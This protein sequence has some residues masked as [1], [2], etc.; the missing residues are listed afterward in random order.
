M[1]S[2]PD[3]RG[4]RRPR[5]PAASPTL[6]DVARLAGVH[7]ATVSR[8]L[9]PEK[10][11]LVSPA[12]RAKVETAARELGYR[13]D[14][15]ARSLR[16]GQTTTVGVVVADLGNLF[17]GSVLRGLA[18][19]LERRGFMAL[20]AETQDDH[21]RLR[22]SLENLLSR[23]VDAVIVTSAR[24]GDE[25]ALQAV[26]QSGTPIVLAVRGIV[27]SDLPTV[28]SDDVAGGALA[29]EYLTKLGHSRIAELSGP[30]DVK[31][32]ADRHVGFRRYLAERRIRPIELRQQ[33]AHPIPSEG[34]RLTE[35][36]LRKREPLPTAIFAHNDSIAIGALAM[37]RDTGLRCPEDVSLLGYNDAPLV[38]HV[39]PPLTTIRFPSEQIG[40]F[41]GEVAISLIEESNGKNVSMSF[42]PELVQ[43]QS[44]RRLARDEDAG[45]A[46]VANA[47]AGRRRVR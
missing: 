25:A 20:I 29:A 22:V 47:A 18:A 24:N 15:V 26:R 39:F 36:L 16:R 44:C 8:S 2:S 32:F 6:R 45:S 12:T 27:G 17:V 23:R 43:R 1:A 46:A 37:L 13:G 19:A 40:R 3:G 41:A 14:V 35:A 5:L 9:D 42:P 7:P 28:S 10:M 38:D 33:A 21:E 4:A 31:P 30:L 34:R 11:S